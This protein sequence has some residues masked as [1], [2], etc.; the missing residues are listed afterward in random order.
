MKREI[1]LD[2]NFLKSSFLGFCTSHSDRILARFELGKM[3]LLKDYLVMK[4][5]DRFS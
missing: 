3:F 1:L 5:S 2:F 4:K